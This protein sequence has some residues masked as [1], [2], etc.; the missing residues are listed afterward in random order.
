VALKGGSSSSKSSSSSKTISTGG[1]SSY[2]S[3]KTTSSSSSAPKTTSS[4]SN[5]SIKSGD[6]LSKIAAQYGTSV[7]ALAAANNIK[8]INKIQAG[9]TLKIP[10]VS[11]G[12][13][14]NKTAQTITPVPSPV[15][16]S[17]TAMSTPMTVSSKVT[18]TAPSTKVTLPN[19]F[20]ATG[21]SGGSTGSP[22][23]K[24]TVASGDTLSKIA[25]KYGT[26]VSALV[27]ANNIADANKIYPGQVFTIPSGGV[28]G[29]GGAISQ[30]PTTPLPVTPTLP[31]AQ[32]EMMSQL[33][34][35]SG[36]TSSF[37]ENWSAAGGTIPLSTSA[38]LKSPS[39][40]AAIKAMGDN[41]KNVN[42]KDSAYRDKLNS[43]VDWNKV[44]AE[45]GGTTVANA[46]DMSMFEG[47][48][49]LQD[50]SLFLS[51]IPQGS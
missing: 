13:S 29:G 41:P 24:H 28:V 47:I 39:I 51:R 1:G 23:T 36:V 16:S 10:T 21:T 4:S 30:K 3:S 6:T 18:S 5:Y 17:Q 27:A 12:G 11:S 48:G 25:S 45:L 35:Q 32:S 22:T 37:A 7:S 14:S 49:K 43:M 9:A 38:L 42:L 44:A 8:D 20:S 50:P 33:P 15:T 34:Q 2:G 31:Q 19:V 40:Q 46:P 26:T